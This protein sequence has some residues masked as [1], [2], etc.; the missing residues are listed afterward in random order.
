M[1]LLIYL[2]YKNRKKKN[3]RTL[4]FVRLAPPRRFGAFFFFSSQRDSRCRA[5]HVCDIYRPQFFHFCTQ[6]YARCCV[7]SVDRLFQS[8]VRRYVCIS[9]LRHRRPPRTMC[10]LCLFTLRVSVVRVVFLSVQLFFL[11]LL[12]GI[13]FFGQLDGL[14]TTHLGYRKDQIFLPWAFFFCSFV[15]TASLLRLLLMLGDSVNIISLL[16]YCQFKE[17]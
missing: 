5:C 12:N 10:V 14:L 17:F 7:L 3:L 4:R 6:C 2:P 1:L 11:W 13:F 15:G 8:S 9:S 16:F